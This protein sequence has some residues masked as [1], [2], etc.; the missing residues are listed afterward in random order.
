MEYKPNNLK[1]AIAVLNDAVLMRFLL[2]FY[3][4][5]SV[6]EYEIP[7]FRSNYFGA[8]WASSHQARDDECW[9]GKFRV[10]VQ[11]R[12]WRILSS[13]QCDFES[14]G[15][16]GRGFK[17]G[18]GQRD[19]CRAFCTRYLG[20][21]TVGSSFIAF[22][23]KGRKCPTLSCDLSKMYGHYFWPHFKNLDK[24]CNSLTNNQ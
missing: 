17:L 1:P 6:Q 8:L 3:F 21:N 7:W 11:S 13:I 9:T 15:H 20:D 23:D 18:L 2:Y 4:T 16:T 24:N 12:I 22:V 10:E 14:P 5:V 19:F